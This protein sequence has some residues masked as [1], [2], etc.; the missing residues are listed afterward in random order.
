MAEKI[1]LIAPHPFYQERGTP[2]AVDLLIQALTERGYIIDL[3]TFNEGINVQYPGLT[4]H[5][6][7]PFPEIKNV[8][9]GFSGKKILLDILIFFKFITLMTK[10]NYKVV[11]AVEESAFMATLICPLYRTPFIYD[12]DSSMATQII[13]KMNFLK[14]IEKLIR[15]IE[16]VPMRRAQIVIPVCQ[17]LADETKKYRS[18][19]IHVLKDV[20]LA[21]NESINSGH[22][23][24]I[25][26]TYDIDGT[27]FMYIGNLESYQGIDLMLEAFS[28]HH[29]QYP[30]SH[31]IIIGGEQ[32]HINYYQTKCQQ[33]SIHES[34]V[35]MGKQPIAQI[36][37]F[38]S[39]A[40]ILLSPRTQGVNTPMKVYSYLD[41]GVVVLATDLPTH[42]Q[43]ADSTTA[44]LC[45]ADEK[46][47]ADG[48]EALSIN[49]ELCNKLAANAKQLIAREHSY[50]VFRAKLYD[51]YD[52]L[53][54]G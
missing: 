12:M 39:Q 20:S 34:V 1:L 51:I 47:F 3:L 35:F 48:M 5:R 23:I 40:N 27:I 28:I 15:L 29:S 49:T 16:S 13:D 4:I 17:A 33:L 9:P 25:R 53:P 22:P 26:S 31:L 37:Q 14:P 50:P 21:K 6:V 42:T 30:D 45:A 54:T 18:Q 46:S 44:Y 10:N 19:G 7:K 2:I 52:D 24:N 36:N 43:V 38:M 41:S 11:H 8:M 32:K